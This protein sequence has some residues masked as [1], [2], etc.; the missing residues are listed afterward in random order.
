VYLGVIVQKVDHEED[1]LSQTGLMCTR[2]GSGGYTAYLL[3]EI[4]VLRGAQVLDGL[5]AEGGIE[6]TLLCEHLLVL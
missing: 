6:Y 2:C 1:V 5:H 3:E 4:K